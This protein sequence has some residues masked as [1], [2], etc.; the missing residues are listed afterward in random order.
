MVPTGTAGLEPATHRLTADCSKPTELSSQMARL[1]SHTA[2][3]EE[4]WSRLY[5]TPAIEIQ[6]T[7]GRYIL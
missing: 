6:H 1:V 7:L 2:C 5:R 3:V 4:F